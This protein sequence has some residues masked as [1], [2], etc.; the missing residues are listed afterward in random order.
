MM[1]SYWMY[2]SLYCQVNSEGIFDILWMCP[3]EIIETVN[4]DA[5]LKP[6]SEIQEIFEK[7]MTIEYEAQ[8]EF[9]G[10]EYDFE[11]DRVTLSLHRV[12]EQDSNETGLLV[13]A[14]NFYGKLTTSY[15]G[16]PFGP[17]DS[18]GESFLT[19]NAIDGSVIDTLKG[20]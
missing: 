15:D 17:V 16:S 5:Q 7:M 9:G 11:I 6:F 4:E 19:I 2:E 10:T 13:P 20:Y 8:A 3:L 18:L 12:V 14:W 1:A